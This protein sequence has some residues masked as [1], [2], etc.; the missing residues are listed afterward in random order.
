MI[1]STDFMSTLAWSL[2]HF[3]WQGAAIAALAAAVMFVYRTPAMRYLI[4]VGALVLMLASFIT[5]FIALDGAADA[6]AAFTPARAPAAALASPLFPEANV[7]E[8]ANLSVTQAATASSNFL[9]V[10]RGWLAGVF[11]LALRIALGLLVIEHLRRRNLL[12][13]PDALVERFQALQERL[14]I[15]RG[16]QYSGCRLVSVPAVI[17]FFRPIVLLPARALTGL[18][19]EQL[20]AVIAHELGHIKRLDVAV[21]FFQVVAETLFFFHPAVWWLNQRIRADREDCCDDVAVAAC[22][23]K[24][25]YARA[26]ATMEDWRGVPAL[27]LAVTGSPIAARIARLL[28]VKQNEAGARTAGVVTA[29]LVLTVAVI[30]GAASLGLARP[31]FAQ[32]LAQA[33]VAAPVPA[34]SAAPVVAPTKAAKP[35]PAAKPAATARPAPAARP[36]PPSPPTPTSPVSPRNP[37]NPPVPAAPAANESFIEEMVEATHEDL[38]VEQ[39]VAL[40]LHD[41]TPE[42]IEEVRNLDINADVEEIITMKIHDVQPEF[43][44]EMRSIGFKPDADQLIAM[45]VHDLSADYVKG[46]RSLGLDIDTDQ[47]IAMKVHNVTPEYVKGLGL[48][49]VKPDTDA[50]IGFK[51]HDVQPDYVKQMKGLG[52][53]VDADEIV[54]MKVHGL[55]PEYVKQ[56]RA[57]GLKPDT[58]QIIAMKVHDVTPEYAKTLER[59]GFKFDVED[60]I[61]AKVMGVDTAFIEKAAAKGF[62]NLTLEKLIALKNADIL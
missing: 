6:S 10:A 24:V 22:G 52:L 26:L 48:L 56:V 42:F 39:L 5:T 49:G 40:K 27:A 21:N 11:V 25:S 44:K 31:A 3:L 1:V 43:L 61:H 58:D 13:L 50:I 9:W 14:G 28:G 45:K 53:N 8:A 20:E 59:A 30:A 35:A 18:S 7:P 34:E 29:S 41:V 62:K 32:I 37:P 2:V 47:M 54:A 17:G 36:N 51:V 23:S 4:G 12:A 57:A 15:R 19:P 55:T 60:L 46:M 33:E 16:I 38:D